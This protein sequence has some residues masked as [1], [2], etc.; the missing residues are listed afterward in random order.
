MLNKNMTKKEIE[1][2]LNT[3]GDFV[4]IDYLTRF[5]KNDPPLELKKFANVKLAELYFKKGLFVDAAKCYDSAG[6][7]SIPF[8][9]KIKNYVKAVEMFVKAASF[10]RADYEMKKALSE[11]NANQRNEIYFNVKYI[12]RTQGEIYEKEKKKNN[13]IRVYEKFLEMKLNTQE[14]EEI[15]EKLLRLYE[16]L[17][18]F[19]EAE[20]LKGL[21]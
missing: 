21:Y 16:D 12:Y 15:K 17:G 13:A 10:E 14:K 1:D 5:L 4:K 8:S 3:K 18:K 7:F 20:R 19:R 2:L 11:G 6:N 9:E